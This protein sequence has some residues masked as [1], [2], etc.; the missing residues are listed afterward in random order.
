MTSSE[1]MNVSVQKK[2]KAYF[3]ITRP[4]NATTAAVAVFAAM[5]L[6]LGVDDKPLNPITYTFISLAAFFTTA[7]SMVHND[8]VD[9]EIDKINS[10]NRPLPSNIISM[11]NAK[12]WAVILIILA[13]SFGL[14]ADSR[15][16]LDFPISF[17][18]ALS[19]AFIL[20]IYNLYI[21]KSGIWGNLVIGYNVWA[22][23][24]YADIVVNTGLTLQVESIGLYAFFWNWGREVI[25]DIIDIEGDE[26]AGVKTIAV[27]FG[28]RGGAI[29]GSSLLGIA[30]IW[31]IPIIFY[32]E[33]SLFLPVALSFINIIIVYRSIKLIKNPSKDY[34]FTT[35]LL[36]LK[37]MLLAVIGLS[38]DQMY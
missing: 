26:A 6:A 17:F 24:I 5:F 36:Y 4:L 38:L 1:T 23:F 14:I 2:L 8:I 3:W 37:L 33:E 12:L 29:V 25:K 11:K 15:L 31:T 30:I 19:N 18:W 32:P 27:R 22:L 28:A 9:L 7:H 10:P 13:C 20:D 34:A 35:K 21:K 16:D